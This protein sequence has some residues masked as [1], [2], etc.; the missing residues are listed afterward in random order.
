LQLQSEDLHLKQTH[1]DQ[2]LTWVSLPET[3]SS[4]PGAP[5][6]IFTK[7][8]LTDKQKSWLKSHDESNWKEITLTQ[9]YTNSKRITKKL[10]WKLPGTYEKKET[11]GEWITKGCDNVCFH[12]DNKKFVRHSKRSCFRSKCE[13]C[14]LEKWLARESHRATQRI[15][16]Y[17]GFF[18]KLQFARSPKFQRKY[19]NPIHVIVSPS[20]KDKFMPYDQLKKKAR[21]LLD[22]AGIE[23]GLMIYHPFGLDKKTEQ[24]IV[25][26]HFHVVGFGWVVDTKK[27]SDSEG[28]VIKNKG[29]R[30][31]RD[32]FSILSVAFRG[33]FL[34]GH[35]A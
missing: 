4:N 31:I 14:W 18:K 25:R 10:T 21:K 27:I 29:L 17:V 19:L 5:K 20:W 8:Q 16:N 9:D 3:R 12:P 26:P 30:G 15:E 1:I 23:G 35:M 28:W 6:A 34:I 13:Y 24:W 7:K 11:C 32:I 22:R 33:S 2:E